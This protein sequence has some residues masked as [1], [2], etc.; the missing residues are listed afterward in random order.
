M[1]FVIRPLPYNH[2]HKGAWVQFLVGELRFH[3]L[4]GT[5]KKKRKEPNYSSLQYLLSTYCVP[6]L[7]LEAAVIKAEMPYSMVGRGEERKRKD[8]FT[9]EKGSGEP[10]RVVLGWGCHWKVWSG[11]AWPNY[12]SWRRGQWIQGAWNQVFVQVLWLLG[13]CSSGAFLSCGGGGRPWG[14]LPWLCVQQGCPQ[15]EHLKESTFPQSQ[16]TNKWRLWPLSLPLSQDRRAQ[17][18]KVQLGRCVM[19]SG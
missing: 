14:P 13:L 16:S 5:V 18:V 8:D 7:G 19:G 12:L 11:K 9:W 3:T 6:G 2:R 4:H 17:C 1:S 10:S 15:D